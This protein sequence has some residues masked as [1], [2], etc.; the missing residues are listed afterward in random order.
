MNSKSL[1]HENVFGEPR[2]GGPAGVWSVLLLGLTDAWVVPEDAL[3]VHTSVHFAGIRGVA[4]T[5]VAQLRT[6]DA[7]DCAATLS[8]RT[9]AALCVA[10]HCTGLLVELQ[11]WPEEGGGLVSS[12][13]LQY[14]CTTYV[15]KDRE[16]KGWAKD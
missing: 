2:A 16:D 12:K 5:Q 11:A 6:Q 7:Q 15:T 3:P 1:K 14:H 4:R 13:K 9:C 8:R 10:V